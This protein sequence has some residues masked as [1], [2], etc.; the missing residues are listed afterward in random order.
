[1][2]IFLAAFA[3]IFSASCVSAEPISY[4]AKGKRDPFVQL[5]ASSKQAAGGLLGV[6]SIDE[7]VVE[8]IM[9]D[10]DPGNSVVVANGSVLKEGEEVG[11][12]KLV[13]IQADGAVFSVNGMEGFK[14]LYVD[15]AK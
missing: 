6:E 10:A 14:A 9:I 5:V 1:M 13:K 12:V 2:W 8:G 11:D 7:I 3:I 4:V 15:E